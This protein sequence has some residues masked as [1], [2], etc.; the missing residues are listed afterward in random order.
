LVG[1]RKLRKPT[2]KFSDWKRAI[3][4]CGKEIKG[5][6]GGVVLYAAQISPQ[7]DTATAEKGRSRMTTSW[8]IS[9]SLSIAGD[10]QLPVCI[11][12]HHRATSFSLTVHGLLPPLLS[13]FKKGEGEKHAE[14]GSKKYW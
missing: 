5:L 12:L 14:D 7:I 2:H 11:V 6:C 3:F 1:I 8:I 10:R 13:V 4:R 9:S